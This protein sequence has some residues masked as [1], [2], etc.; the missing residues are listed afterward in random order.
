MENSSTRFVE[1]WEQTLDML[2]LEISMENLNYIKLS[3]SKLIEV[4]ENHWKKRAGEREESGMT[5][6]CKRNCACGS[7]TIYVQLE[8]FIEYRDDNTHRYVVANL[9]MRI[10]FTAATAFSKYLL[11]LKLA[12]NTFSHEKSGFWTTLN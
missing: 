11:E 9:R 7:N 3:P 1:C 5:Y 4:P 12:L 2:I 10:I 8:Q 6:M